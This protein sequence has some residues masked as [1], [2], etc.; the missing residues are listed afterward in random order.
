MVLRSDYRPPWADAPDVV[1]LPVER[2]GREHSEAM[3]AGLTEERP[4]PAELTE[5]ILAATD[6]VPLFVEE[7]TKSLLES[8]LL[9]EENGRSVLRRPLPPVD[10][11]ATIQDSLTARLDH[12]GDAKLVAQIASTIGREFSRELLAAVAEVPLAALQVSLARL[13]QSGL[14]LPLGASEEHF[15]FKHA[16]VRDAAYD[17]LLR[18][19]RRRLHGRIV[20]VLESSFPA[21]ISANPELAAKHSTEAQ[22]HEKAVHYWL[23]AGRQAVPRAA[24]VEAVSHLEH[25]LQSLQ[26]VPDTAARAALRLECLVTLG[27]SLILT[28]GPGAQRVEVV[29][30]QAVELC[31]RVEPSLHHIAAFWGWW[32]IS[33]GYEAMRDRAERLLALAQR[34]AAPAVVLQAHHCMWATRLEMAEFDDA[35][36]HVAVGLEV[37][38][39]GDYAGQ[40]DYFG[41]HDAKVCGSGAAAFAF[42]HLGEVERALR[43]CQGALEWAERLGHAGSILHAL[44]IAVTFRRYRR[45]PQAARELAERMIEFGRERGLNEH[46]AKGELYLGWTLAA[47]GCREKVSP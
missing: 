39:Q 46:L 34:L 30:A 45:E 15:A 10:I 19:T 33:P 14:V 1:P 26:Q 20:E 11:P 22:A 18:S 44:D 41:G 43:L 8:D 35:C 25:A 17:S 29:Y 36:Q 23:L 21:I 3:V 4:L 31:E 9:G 5:Q 38:D 37:Y 13:V 28:Q 6:G 47:G 32:R 27:P 42:W 16:L 2:L 7:L 40:A 24:H 12:L